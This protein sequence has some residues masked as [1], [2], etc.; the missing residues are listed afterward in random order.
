M[1]AVRHRA[2]SS[3]GAVAVACVLALAACGTDERPQPPRTQSPS[4][5]TITPEP[6]ASPTGPSPSPTPSASPTP[7]PEPSHLQLPPDAPSTVADAR[8]LT[9]IAEG[10]FGS[11][12][13]PG[14]TVAFTEVTAA[15]FEQIAVAWERGE[16]PFAAERGFV[17]WQRTEDG[18]AWRAVY[19]FTDAPRRAVLGIQR[20]QRGDLTGD[21]VDELVTFE[22]RGGSGACGVTRVI[23]PRAGAADEIYTR[24][25][26]DAETSVVGTA[27]E[28]REAVYGPDDPHCCPSAFR[29]TT[30]E[31]D[32]EGFV[33][34]GVAEESV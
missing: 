11:L 22:D 1:T 29:T 28:V 32:G 24:A 6:T 26:C 2:G 12:V 10:D 4:P 3:A 16:D 13:P 31:W 5:A 30:L 8:A 17:L 14:A 20:P 15:P 21:G 7:V 23:S 9:D 19:A 27:L 34:T 18:S 33:E 25:T